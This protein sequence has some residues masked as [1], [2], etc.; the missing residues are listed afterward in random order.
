[1]NFEC[2]AFGLKAAQVVLYSVKQ[3]LCTEIGR[4]PT[5][6][7]SSAL[8]CLMSFYDLIL[9]HDSSIQIYFRGGGGRG[10]RGHPLDLLSN[11]QF[12]EPI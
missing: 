12:I 3:A 5:V 2:E 4:W 8:S 1:M 9:Y 11:N 6:I 10:V 7:Y